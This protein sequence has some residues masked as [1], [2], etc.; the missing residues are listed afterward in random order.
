M[1]LGEPRQFPFPELAALRHGHINVQQIV[2]VLG[3]HT[4]EAYLKFAFVRNPFDRFVSYCAFVSRHS[5]QFERDPRGF[6]RQVLFEVRP[7]GHLLFRPQYEF[8]S[9]SS[10]RVRLDLIGRQETLQASFD[11]ICD[12]LGLPGTRLEQVNA[13]RRVE[14][15]RYYEPDLMAAVAT[16]YAEDFARFGYPTLIHADQSRQD[17]GRA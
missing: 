14:F 11:Q 6:M 10:G 4:F 16:T 8:V 5:G 9:D 13:S 1:G 15:W 7:V 3:A 12:Q 17:P 2:P